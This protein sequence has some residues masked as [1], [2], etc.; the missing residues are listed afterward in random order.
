MNPFGRTK[1]CIL[2]AL[3]TAEKLPRK[4]S[5]LSYFG[6]CSCQKSVFVAELMFFGKKGFFFAFWTTSVTSQQPEMNLE[7][8]WNPLG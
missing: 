3:Y 1:F 6:K 4:V 7:I 8:H 2:I 5:L